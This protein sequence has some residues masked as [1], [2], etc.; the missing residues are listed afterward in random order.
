MWNWLLIQKWRWARKRPK[1]MGMLSLTDDYQFKDC[2]DE[3]VSRSRTSGRNLRFSKRWMSCSLSVWQYLQKSF[4]KAGY[5]SYKAQQIW[6][7]SPGAHDSNLLRGSPDCRMMDWSVPIL[8]S[9]WSGTGT[10]IVPRESFF[11]IAMWLP[12]PRTSMKPCVA[13]VEHTSFAREDSKFTQMPP[14][15][16]LRKSHHE[17]VV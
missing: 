12:R 7:E 15:L 8:I 1:G 17:D 4:L 9:S 10:V 2:M 6:G 3:V 16:G 5:P 14:R 13:K 11:C